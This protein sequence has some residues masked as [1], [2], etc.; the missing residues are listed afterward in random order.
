LYSLTIVNSGRALVLGVPT[1]EKLWADKFHL[2]QRGELVPCSIEKQEHDVLVTTT[3]ERDWMIT[4]TLMILPDEYQVTA[5]LSGAM[6]MKDG[7]V[8]NGKKKV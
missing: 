4:T 8:D 3:K 2:V 6:N 1:F 5:D 7:L